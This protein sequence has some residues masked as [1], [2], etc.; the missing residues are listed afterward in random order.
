MGQTGSLHEEPEQSRR[1]KRNCKLEAVV[2]DLED[3][4]DAKAQASEE[5]DEDEDWLVGSGYA[6]IG[7]PCTLYKSPALDA[8]ECGNAKPG[9]VLVL[10]KTME[11]ASKTVWGL[12]EPSPM[13]KSISTGW[14]M[15]EDPRA[16]PASGSSRPLV[17]KPDLFWEVNGA[18]RARGGAIVRATSDLAS[19]R[20]CNLERGDMLEVLEFAVINEEACGGTASPADQKEIEKDGET[21]PK[22]RDRPKL[23]AKVLLW[24]SREIGWVTP[25]NNDGVHLLLPLKAHKLEVFGRESCKLP[26]GKQRLGGS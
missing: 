13:A 24:K 2:A 19:E 10:M 5:P 21:S 1:R 6:V 20:V 7:C 16:A 15:L 18:Y 14:A 23:R 8:E 12:L 25:R 26:G 3:A 9:S 22:G 11:G 17:R 4:E